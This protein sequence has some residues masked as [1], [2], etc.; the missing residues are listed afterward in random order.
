[1][2]TLDSVTE[3]GDDA[4]LTVTRD[5]AIAVFSRMKKRLCWCSIKNTRPKAIGQ[6]QTKTDLPISK[7]SRV[8]S[9]S[10]VQGR[11]IEMMFNRRLELMALRIRLP[12]AVAQQMKLI[13]VHPL[14]LLSQ[15]LTTRQMPT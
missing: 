8:V 14:M 3:S 4:T 11:A 10:M 2:Y 9:F 12:L 15:I 1:M 7:A 5:S 6:R 13:L